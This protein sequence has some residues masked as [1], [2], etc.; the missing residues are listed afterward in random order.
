MRE[1]ILSALKEIEAEYQVSI[2][3]ACESGSRA[4]GFASQ[5]SDYDVRF[6][7][8]HPADW[9]L[10][11][12][13]ERDVNERQLPG[14]LDVSGWELRKALRLFRKSNPPMLEWLRSPIIYSHNEHFLEELRKIDWHPAAAKGDWG[15]S[16]HRCHRHYYSMARGNVRNYFESDEVPLKK[17]LY[18]LRPIL[19][20]L[21]IEREMSAPPVAFQELIDAVVA[22]PALRSAIVELVERK[23]AG[24]ELGKGQKIKV[25]DGFAWSEMER[26][27]EKSDLPDSQASTDGLNKLFVE[28][29]GLKRD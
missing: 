26:L 27:A 14:D 2:L 28:T 1:Q 23:K 9:Y 17:Y 4:W 24:V 5:D 18:V 7:Y 21:W 15:F 6:V 25:I 13:Q 19:A 12:D 11:I 20:C 8:A 16:P 3:F 29:I 22:E 10:S